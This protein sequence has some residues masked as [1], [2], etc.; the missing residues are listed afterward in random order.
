M[1]P[2]RCSPSQNTLVLRHLE[3]GLSLTPLDALNAFGC[4]RLGARIHE[5]KAKGYAIETEYE[6]RAGKRFAVYRLQR[7]A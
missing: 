1:T 5:L 7:A 2:T 3:Q 6:T 4:F